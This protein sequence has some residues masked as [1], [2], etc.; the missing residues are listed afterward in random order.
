VG[1]VYAFDRAGQDVE[2]DGAMIWR[3]W[4]RLQPII[5][6]V[7]KGDGTV[8]LGGGVHGDFTKRVKRKIEFRSNRLEEFSVDID[9][10]REGAEQ[11]SVSDD[12]QVEANDSPF[13]R[14]TLVDDR[15]CFL[16]KR[17]P[18]HQHSFSKPT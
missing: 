9:H 13:G 16:R 2:R 3:D 14:N 5:P 1:V 10:F 18:I 4:S 11:V 12:L 8:I 7:R 6:G 17:I 15:P